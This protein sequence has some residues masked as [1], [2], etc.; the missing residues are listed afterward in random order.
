LAA[1]VAARKPQV[2]VLMVQPPRLERGTSRST[3]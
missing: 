2:N 1:V 3:I